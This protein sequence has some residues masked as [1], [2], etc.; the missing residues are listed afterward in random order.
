MTS[1][2]FKIF[3]LAVFAI[4]FASMP[5]AHAA[6]IDLLL[7]NGTII[8]GTGG[9]PYTGSVAVADDKIVAVGDVDE[10]SVAKTIDCTGL[11]IA[12]GFIDLHNHSDDSILKK[13][14]QSALCYLTQGCT[15]LVTGN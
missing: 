1:P 15:T 5:T 12:P 14:N 2:R 4:Y 8:D 10:K 11:V 9:E 7:K 3:V 6:D 13:E